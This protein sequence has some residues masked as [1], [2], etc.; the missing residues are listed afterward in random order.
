MPADILLIT[1]NA[2]YSH[3]AFGLRCLKA[4]MGDLAERTAILEF[5]IN[6]PVDEIIETILKQDA[7]ILSFGIYIWN[8]E[9][10][11]EI[12]SALKKINPDLP[13]LAGGPEVSHETEKSAF[14]GLCDTIICGEGEKSFPKAVQAILNGETLPPLIE[15][16]PCLDLTDV[17]LPYD[18]YTQEDI[19]HKLIYVEASRGCPYRCAFCLSALDRKMR[20]VD[21]EPLYAEFEKLLKRGVRAFKFVDRTFNTD[22]KRA[23]RLLDFFQNSGYENLTLHFEVVPDRLSERLLER[24]K[25]FPA[26]SL[27][28]EVGVQ[29]LTEKTL[30]VIGRKQMTERTCRNI[31]RLAKETSAD[32]HADL[33][34]GLPFETLESFAISFNRLLACGPNHIQLGILKRLKGAPLTLLKETEDFVFSDTA[35][36]EIL[37]TPDMSFETLMRI[38]RFA[39][40]FDLYHNSENFGQSMALFFEMTDNPFTAFMDFS[41]YIF[42][43]TGKTHKFAL[44]KL[45]KLLFAYMTAHGYDKE[46]TS[47]CLQADFH[48]LPGRKDKLDF[49]AA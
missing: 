32:V 30:E 36:F 26:D 20:Y 5:T 40:Y 39:R 42:K 43:E 18:L 45:V 38:K 29:S 48:R 22:D 11:Y 14:F 4:N 3:T 2:R 15:P 17:T 7:A 24:M 46:E 25:S 6:D 8:T 23:I 34:A 31:T 28:L 13:I 10:T 12:I 27:H 33:V 21:E 16:T 9:K 19:D 37:Q 47:R 41:D 49:L 35:P 44:V 1:L